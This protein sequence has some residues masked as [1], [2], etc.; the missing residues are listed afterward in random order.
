MIEQRLGEQTGAVEDPLQQPFLAAEVLDELRLARPRPAG[1]R[2]GRGV[3]VAVLGEEI[4][5]RLQD[6]I[7]GR[8]LRGLALPF[9]RM[10]GLSL[11]HKLK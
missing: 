6:A 10:D 7:V 4:A 11:S 8:R 2:R 5:P 1:D 9:L 3:L